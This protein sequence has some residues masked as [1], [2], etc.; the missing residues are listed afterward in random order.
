METTVML[1]AAGLLIL[2]SVLGSKV[3]DRLGLPTLLLFLVIGMLAGSEGIGG[4]YFD[5]FKTAHAVGVVALVF[6]LFYGGM[7][8]NWEKVKPVLTQSALLS[9]A[10]TL[11]TGVVVA[12]AA[13]VFFKLEL[14]HAMLLGAVASST[15][16]AAVFSVLRSK[17]VNLKDK[18]KNI[19]EFESGS[20]DP[21]AIFMTIGAITL[22]MNP[23]YP[24]LAIA[25]SFL[26]EMSLGV[27]VGYLA[28]RA[29]VFI[30]NK[31]KIEYEGLYPILALSLAMTAYA[32]AAMIKGNGF[33]AVYIAGLTAG[34]AVFMHKKAVLRFHE[35]FAWLMQITMFLT[36]GLLVFPSRLAGI[37]LEGIVISAVLIFA[38]R[39]TAVFLCLIGSG[40]TFKEKLLI[41][42][43]GLRGAAPIILATFPYI[44]AVTGAEQIFNIV[45]FVV[46]I[47]A[48]I[49]GTTV[50]PLSK[51]LGLHENITARK[52]YPIEFE[53]TGGTSAELLEMVVPFDSAATGRAI[54]ELGFPQ[55]SLVAMI[56]R[57]DEFIIPNGATVIEAADVLLVIAEKTD[58]PTV[59]SIINKEKEA[60][61]QK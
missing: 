52:K 57:G 17:G 40:L 46:L 4:I 1:F 22:I 49:Q 7:D 56:S 28:G 11:I 18:V 13:A 58:L 15:D 59:N 54:H 27:V 33:L 37:A 61:E 35:G 3:S 32:G 26:L 36:L 41:S 24:P 55:K 43:V 9:I 38:A 53:Y 45:F 29:L 42:W 10:G 39:P 19:L 6:I 8:T 20:N 25:G 60:E 23:G 47:S 31:I 14:K 12:A 21:M 2:L 5:N 48:A 50:A 44:Y 51:L 16:A 30:L 34:R